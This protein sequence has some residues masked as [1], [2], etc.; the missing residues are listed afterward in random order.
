MIKRKLKNSPKARVS[1]LKTKANIEA[2][3]NSA[4][5]GSVKSLTFGVKRAVGRDSQGHVSIRHRGGGAKRK[6]RIIQTLKQ[7]GMGPFEVIRFEY[8]P[9]R[10]AN[11]ALI[12]NSVGELSYIIAPKDTRV[13]HKLEY[14]EKSTVAP[15]NR[16]PLSKIPTGIEVHSI[17]I[18]PSSSAKMVRSAG[19]KATVMAHEAGMTLL[20]LP[21]GEIRRFSDKCEASV[22]SL[23]N[24]N[25]SARK[26]GK[27]GIKRH[28]GIR[29]TVRGLAM[30][31]AAHPH[32]GGEGGSSIG[33]KAPKTPWGKRTLGVKTR[34]RFDRGQFIVSRRSKKRK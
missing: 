11:I 28:M 33:M 15:G 12:K 14:G 4:K 22:G 24:E 23:G 1:Q 16:L 31:P 20:K 34:K 29:P 3:K 5:K 21:S 19:S 30:H 8:D 6:Y 17:E 25:H 26:I 10:S 13:G 2:V 9:N 27:A 18:T 32:G 7:C